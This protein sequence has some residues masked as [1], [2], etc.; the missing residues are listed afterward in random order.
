[1][2]LLLKVLTIR[3]T[4]LCV[5]YGILTEN[6]LLNKLFEDYKPDAMPRQNASAAMQIYMDMRL[7][8]IE[9][10]DEKK[11]T[12]TVRAFLE[13]KWNDKFLSWR[14]ETY[15][16]VKRINIP[17]NKI[18]LPDLALL[19][20]YDSLTNLG[21]IDGRA[22]V[23]NFG[24]VI[25][26]PYKMYT[27]GCKIK[28]RKFPFDVQICELDFLSWTNPLSVLNL[29]TSVKKVQLDRYSENGEWWLDGVRSKYYLQPYGYD[30]WPHV[31][32][33]FTLRR[34]WLFYSLN[35]IAP[36][37]CISLLNV[38]CFL[39]PAASGEK[40]TLC[41]STFL[42]LAVFLTIITNSLPESSDELSILGCYVGLQ[43]LGSGLTILCTVI[44]LRFYT[45]DSSEHVPFLVQFLCKMCCQK[46]QN[47]FSP[48]K[49][50]S[51]STRQALEERKMSTVSTHFTIAMEDSGV[52]WVSASNA[53]DRLCLIMS[54]CWHVCLFLSL[55][56]GYLQ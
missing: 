51:S 14:P 1:M 35:I 50:N 3:F 56:I 10:V 32:Y 38:F 46:N 27:V 48:F 22:V 39:L 43:L 40:V 12:F 4:C 25:M 11:Q 52:T 53:F 21:Q 18:W 55:V 20:T 26:W 19:D 15:A 37:V 49:R 54:I 41:I 28:V 31:K 24:N 16:G 45:K 6:D 42:T 8:S 34:K 9:T 44:S 17:N 36:I 5:S 30:S 13:I 33:T 29:Q 23:D 47:N 2:H 7:L